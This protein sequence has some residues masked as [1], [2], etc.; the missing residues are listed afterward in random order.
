[1]SRVPVRIRLT[2]AFALAVVVVLAGACGFVYVQLRADADDA[3]AGT[4]DAR[5][6]A[7]L[8]LLKRGDSLTE[9][10]AGLIGEHDESVAQ[11]L[12]P[13]GRVLGSLGAVRGPALQGEDLR[14]ATR[15]RVLVEQRLAGFDDTARVLARPVT[16]RGG[17]RVVAVGAS[18]GDRNEALRALVHSFLVAGF[19]AVV[20]ASLIGYALAAAGLA[21]VESMR[22][23][24][25]EIS[26]GG[27]PER[28][29][30]APA[31]DEIR[32][33]GETLNEMLDRLRRSFDRERRFVADASHELRSPIAVIKTE[34]EGVLRSGRLAPEA[35]VALV[36]AVEEC[37]RLAQLAEDLLVLARAADGP[38][39]TR[40]E[41]LRVQ[42]LLESARERFVDRAAERGRTISVD[43]PADL[44]VMGD[45]LRLR[46]ALGNLVDNAVRHGAG[47]IA[48][49]AR[50][51]PDGVEIDVRDH[52][53]GFGPDF[54]ERAF[55][56][57]TRASESRSGD[58]A[59]LGLAIV[60]AIAQAHG[61][62]AAIVDG[63]S[64]ATVRIALPRAVP[65]DLLPDAPGH[66]VEG[67]P[68]Q[69][70]LM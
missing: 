22:R 49:A 61:G 19:L 60:Q 13:D 2:L 51:T 54:A 27:G 37:D 59:G 36:A 31:H 48:L 42:V 38:L 29:P 41:P 56:R 64:G 21:P 8:T 65:A 69:A 43:A 55:E 5:M 58:G 32:R 25:S 24:A 33:L 39:P 7:A 67:A 57:F 1:V 3:I 26:M 40:L 46:Q 47:D 14:R 63:A 35:R 9:T 23:R 44:A 4:L 52:G 53:G 68:S 70:P 62:S 11:L 30:L 10:D 16:G 17:P 6:T 15:E 20:L 28:L 50:A 45:P 34:L 12:T 18:L 66:A